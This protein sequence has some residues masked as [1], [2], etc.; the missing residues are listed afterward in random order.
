MRGIG[1]QR[2]V[3]SLVGEL[4]EGFEGIAPEKPTVHSGLPRWRTLGGG[5]EMMRHAMLYA[6]VVFKADGDDVGGDMPYEDVRSWQIK[7]SWLVLNRSRHEH[8]LIP[9]EAVTSVEIRIDKE[10]DRE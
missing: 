7:G 10:V 3:Q 4:C 9:A 2:R 1:F 8:I 5:E 6:V